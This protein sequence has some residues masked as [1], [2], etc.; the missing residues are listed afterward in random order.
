[1]AARCV[2]KINLHVSR[3]LGILIDVFNF[4]R[5][6]K[7]IAILC[8]ET[9]T[10][11]TTLESKTAADNAAAVETAS[12]QPNALAGIHQTLAALEALF[13][14]QISRNQNQIKMFDALYREMKDYKEDFLLEALHKPIIK[15][16]LSVYDSFVLLEAQLEG[17]LSAAKRIRPKA[18]AEQLT[19]FRQNL[20]NARFELEEVLYRMDVTPYEEHPETLDRQLH[21]TLKVIPA[22]TPAQD[23]KVA[24]VHKIGFSWRGKVFRPE[25]VTIFRYTSTDA[26]GATSNSDTASE[27]SD[28]EG[29]NETDG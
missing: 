8:K 7:E 19:Q 9:V 23:W 17:M 22:E 4:S 29:E 24:E 27:A 6:K 14:K 1:M 21:K 25:E 28:T 13:E 18:M 11:E 12:A 10:D 15:D 2:V 3:K 20:E 26:V 16:L 5:E